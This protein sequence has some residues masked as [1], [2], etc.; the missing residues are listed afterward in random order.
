MTHLYNPEN[1]NCRSRRIPYADVAGAQRRPA[2]FLLPAESWRGTVALCDLPRYPK[3]GGRLDVFFRVF[4]WQGILFNLPFF[5][6]MRSSGVEKVASSRAASFHVSSY[7]VTLTTS[8]EEELNAL[9]AKVVARI[10]PRVE[11][12]G[13]LLRPPGCK[14][15]RAV[16]ANGEFALVITGLCTR[17]ATRLRPSM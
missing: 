5:S 17:S 6:W 8:A 7:L 10:V 2:E 9:P 16:I 13:A 12:L 4:C 14:N 15:S 1:V 3:P 11:R